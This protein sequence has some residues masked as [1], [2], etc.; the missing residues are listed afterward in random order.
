MNTEN[1]KADIEL[2]KKIT[3]HWTGPQ[4]PEIERDIV[5][6][7]LERLYTEIKYGD[8]VL[9]SESAVDAERQP[10]AEIPSVV[11]PQSAS[12]TE[13]SCAAES[14][15]AQ[16][17]PEVKISPD[18]RPE[19]SGPQSFAEKTTSAGNGAT[20]VSRPEIQ[21][22]LQGQS[23]A[24]SAD[25]DAESIEQSVRR[26]EPVQASFAAEATAQ[27]VPEKERREDAG[28]PASE[29]QPEGSGR[30]ATSAEM[31]AAEN[32]RTSQSESSEEGGRQDSAPEPTIK[33][34]VDRS[35]IRSLYGDP[36]TGAPKHSSDPQPREQNESQPAPAFK[37]QPAAC[38]PQTKVLGDVINQGPT[39]GDALQ[40]VAGR[41][42]AEKIASADTKTLRGAIGLNDRFLMIRDLFGGDA[43]AFDKALSALEEFTEL[44]EAL[45]YIN[46]NYDWNPQSRGAEMLVELL[47]RKLS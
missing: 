11:T 1:I 32:L 39:L 22:S 17:A 40:G 47:V 13:I 16:K 19:E 15:A 37:P 9:P 43:A 33:R 7:M 34:P 38:A 23:E 27:G 46:D 44:E 30:T 2:L 29:V 18:E 12:R 25:K 21:L 10:S 42:M 4:V 36:I 24:A 35:V 45:L 8:A 31:H 20:T 41:D 3:G 14:Y 6:S 5:A 26:T 28:G